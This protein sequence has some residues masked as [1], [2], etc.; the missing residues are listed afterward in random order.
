MLV[1]K[2]YRKARQGIGGVKL[3]ADFGL[4]NAD[5]KIGFLVGF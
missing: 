5:F 4:Q 1:A 3:I 2:S